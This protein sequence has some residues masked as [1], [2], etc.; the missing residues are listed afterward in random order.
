[1]NLDELIAALTDLKAQGKEI[2]KCKVLFV[3]KK[4]NVKPI[5]GIRLINTIC[6]DTNLIVTL[7]EY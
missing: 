3:T 1:M 2:S 4:G 6:P 5:G 7:S